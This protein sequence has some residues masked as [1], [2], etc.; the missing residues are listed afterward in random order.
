MGEQVLQRQLGGGQTGAG[1]VEVEL[2]RSSVSEALQEA[3]L[4]V[5]GWLAQSAALLAVDGDDVSLQRHTTGVEVCLEEMTLWLRNAHHGEVDIVCV[6][7]REM[8]QSR[9][10]VDD[11]HSAGGSEAR[12]F[13]FVA[14]GASAAPHQQHVVRGYVR[15][16]D[17]LRA[18]VP[19][20]G[21]HEHLPSH[22][23]LDAEVCAEELN[24]L[25]PA[26][27]VEAPPEPT[28]P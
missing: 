16:V 11:H 25:R 10:V 4:L 22:G 24:G 9:L 28:R 7:A 17:Q 21:E 19:G 15:R 12:V 27:D 14:E 23:R 5:G 1:G 2:Q 13:G 18:G 8:V 26:V 6:G 3:P 20:L